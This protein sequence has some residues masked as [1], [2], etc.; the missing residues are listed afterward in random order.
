MFVPGSLN[1]GHA[2]VQGGGP[3]SD[4]DRTDLNPFWMSVSGSVSV[5]EER[6]V[7][8]FSLCGVDAPLDI[9]V[10]AQVLPHVQRYVSSPP[11]PHTHTL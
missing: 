9:D 3:T 5:E 11:P 8:F 4:G 1:L 2:G 6:A 7:C 10:S